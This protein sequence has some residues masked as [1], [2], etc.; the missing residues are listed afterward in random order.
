MVE[1]AFLPVVDRIYPRVTDRNVC[2]TSLV[3]IYSKK[4]VI[5]IE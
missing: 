4:A 2:A 5:I 3:N 1:Q